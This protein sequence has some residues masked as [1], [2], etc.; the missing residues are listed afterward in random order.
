MSMFNIYIIRGGVFNMN[1]KGRTISM[2]Q[3]NEYV[4]N[5]REQERAEN[6]VNQYKSHLIHF[7]L[8]L[9]GRMLTKQEAIHWKQQ[10]SEK[11]ASSTVNTMLAAVNGF[12]RYM[13]WN[14]VI[15]KLLKVQKALFRDESRE[16][17]CK[18]YE[19]LVRAADRQGN[20]RVSLL[21]QT[22]C[23]TGIRVSELRFITVEAVQKGKTEVFNKGKRRM[24]FLP[25][26]L[27]RLLRS[28]IQSKNIK[29]GTIF[30]TKSGKPIDRSNIWRYMKALCEKAGVDPTKVFP[31]NLRHLF[32]RMFY[33]KEKDAYRLADVLGHSSINTTRIYTL[34][35]GLIHAKLI[36][37]M[38][39]VVTT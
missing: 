20:T 13:G 10:L 7:V 18:E 22:I 16:L 12:F 11:Y 35:S 38:Q 34:E 37:R 26:Q 2:D 17:S 33:A 29:S 14:D 36:N 15:V 25:T 4:D 28:Y 24:I 39:L 19:R 27:C 21:I 30:I 1:A 9:D 32:A 3:I 23:A 8:W 31:H 5:L 6:T